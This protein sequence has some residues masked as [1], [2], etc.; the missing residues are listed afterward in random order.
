MYDIDASTLIVSILFTIAISSPFVYHVFKNKKHRKIL[1]DNF[2][3]FAKTIGVNPSQIEN[4]RNIYF[5]GY[6]P[7]A[8]IVVYLNGGSNP[9]QTFIN[10]HEVAKISIQEKTHLVESGVEKRNVLDYLGIQ[11]NFK[12]HYKSEKLIEIYNSELFS[13]QDGEAVM[14]KKWVE[15]LNRQLNN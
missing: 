6:D 14:A 12:D 15:L 11:F 4:W 13:G 1:M 5:L 10:L 7:N 9:E 8:K 2:Q 3:N